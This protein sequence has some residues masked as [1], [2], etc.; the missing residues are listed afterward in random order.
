VR[1]LFTR[2]GRGGGT[3]YDPGAD[4]FDDEYPS[5]AHQDDNMAFD[6]YGDEAGY[7]EDV[8][9]DPSV[10]AFP[11]PSA[12]PVSPA[13]LSYHLPPAYEAGLSAGY[14]IGADDYAQANGAHDYPQANG[15]HAY[16]QANG[17][18]DGFRR[19]RSGMHAAPESRSQ[20]TGEL[21]ASPG[22]YDYIRRH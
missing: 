5:Y 11:E 15:A 3:D 12:A 18:P 2:R 22:G 10:L 7:W 6:D 4:Y 21:F 16:P 9:P 20:T 14:P 13:A 19:G 1:S 8:Q 17:A